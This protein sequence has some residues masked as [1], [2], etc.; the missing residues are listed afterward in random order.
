MRFK[1]CGLAMSFRSCSGAGIAA[2]TVKLT[3]PIFHINEVAGASADR[4]AGIAAADA[5][6][7]R[8]CDAHS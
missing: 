7:Q 6:G 2:M 5:V 3:S 1:D 4:R 8:C